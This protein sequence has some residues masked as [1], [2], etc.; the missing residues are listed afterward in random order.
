MLLILDLD[1]TL[2]HAR[3]D[4]LDRAADFRVAHYHVYR[5]PHLEAFIAEQQRHFDLAVWSSASDDYVA[6]VVKEIFP[7]PENLKFVWGRSRATLRHD[8]EDPWGRSPTASWNHLHYVKP[9]AKVRRAGW[10]LERVLIV[11]DTPAKCARNYG[12]AVYA[13]PY[14]GAEDDTELAQLSAYLPKLKD[15]AD[16]RRIEK[17]GWREGLST[18]APRS[19]P[20]P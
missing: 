10:P 18:P 6:E 13:A 16:V 5:R 3:R 2:I 17:R 11:D 4:P 12:N 20:S 9:L 15:E 8:F 14:E 7:Q 19:P 1:E